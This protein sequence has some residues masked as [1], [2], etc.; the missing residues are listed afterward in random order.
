VGE[1]VV[2]ALNQIG[3]KATLKKVTLDDLFDPKQGP[4]MQSMLVNWFSDA[5][6]S[7]SFFGIF[8]CDDPNNLSRFCDPAFDAAFKKALETQ[9][10]NT[11]GAGDAWAAVDRM[12]VDEAPIAALVDQLEA[13]F[14]SV[15]VGNF[16]HHPEWGILL[17]QL[18]VQ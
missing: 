3:F 6:S 14:V 10:T 9:Q 2:A 15:R 16:Q 4:K 8:T 7:A 13:D 1:E 12:L 5:G 17:D 11:A 18:W